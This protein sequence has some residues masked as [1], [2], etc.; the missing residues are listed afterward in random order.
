MQF[1]DRRLAIGFVV[2]ACGLLADIPLVSAQTRERDL[3]TCFVHSVPDPKLA[4]R[5]AN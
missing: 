4:S 2:V 5:F 3:P 1:G